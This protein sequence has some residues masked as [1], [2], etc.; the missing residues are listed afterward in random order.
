[1]KKIISLPILLLLSLVLLLPSCKD[2]DSIPNEFI[3]NGEKYSLARGFIESYG[4]NGN[5][6][7]DFDVT[8]VS[9]GIS[10]LNNGD[11]SGIGEVI[12]LD[13]NTSSEA[14]LVTGTY[15]YASSTDTFNFIHA[16][17]GKDFHMFTQTGEL[18]N[19]TD[20]TIDITTNGGETTIFFDLIISNGST[21][22]GSFK[23]TL[24]S[25]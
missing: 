19:V 9:S 18:H 8:L 13:M 7:F 3:L 25:R 17:V 20:G 6:S 22:S 5:G 21:V 15:T 16:N 24:Q 1:M 10:L 12:Y 14:G 2:D 4:S 23:G 11:Y